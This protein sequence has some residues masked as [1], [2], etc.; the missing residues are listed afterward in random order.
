MEEKYKTTIDKIMR[1]C[2]QNPEFA[3]ELRERLG[4]NLSTRSMARSENRM[5]NVEKYLGLDYY[6]DTQD[7]NVDYSFVKN[8]AVRAQLISDNREMMRFRYGTRYHEIDFM[9]FCR[10]AHLQAEMLLNYYY[11]T[12]NN[13]DLDS[14]KAHIKQ[15]NNKANLDN[16]VSIT[17][18]PYNVKLWAFNKEHKINFYVLDNIRKVRNELSHRGIDNEQVD[19]KTYQ[20]YLM[21]LGF[22]LK[23]T[24]EILIN[25]NDID[26]DNKVKEIYKT[27]IQPSEEYKRYVYYIWYMS[28]PYDSI[29][30][31]I[32]S[33]S[34]SVPL[35][36]SSVS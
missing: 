12:V 35:L 21:D 10:Y 14:I 30:D 24:G 9:E 8:P 20:K 6:V 3:K 34:N 7:S 36:T 15:Y 28:K 5:R 19:I 25:W 23:T 16:A 4:I 17:T 2:S 26:A 18:I 1:V 11:E 33:L 27:K 29:I 22:K 32:K 31:G 13:S